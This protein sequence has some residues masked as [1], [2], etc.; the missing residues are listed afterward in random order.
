MQRVLS[1]PNATDCSPEFLERMAH[2][3]MLVA[4]NT[5]EIDLLAQRYEFTRND[6]SRFALTLVTS[7]GCN[8]TAPTASRR[9]IRRSCTTMSSPRCSP[10]S[11][12]NSP[13][14]RASMPRGSAASPSSARSR[15]SSCPTRSTRGAP[16]LASSTRRASST[17]GYLLDEEMAAQLRDRVVVSAQV[18]LDG[19]PDIH[20][21]MRPLQN[22]GE[23]FWRIVRNLQVAVDYLPITIRMNVDTVN[24]RRTKELFEIL[25]EQGL[26]GRLTAYQ[27]R[28]WASTTAAVRPR[29]RTSPPASRT[30]SS[31]RPSSSSTSSPASTASVDRSCRA[32]QA[33][34]APPFARNELVVGSEGEL[35]KCWDSVGNQR[36]VI[37]SIFDHANPNTRLRKW[38]VYDPFTDAECRGCIALTGVHGRMR[39]SRDGPHPAREPLLDL[40]PHVPRAGQHLRRARRDQRNTV[41]V[42]PQPLARAMDTR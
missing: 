17:N 36:E 22:G 21:R 24:I 41:A 42:G 3:R 34:R 23:T 27:V 6:P 1:D 32:L 2:G 11:T 37:G 29:S 14:S 39:P 33:R 28:S 7:L 38:L 19:P 35:Y 31:R 26:S 30:P 15:Y 13:G 25:A 40:P 16:R 10:R 8:S 20:D 4:D 12:N 5:D 18:C 9:S